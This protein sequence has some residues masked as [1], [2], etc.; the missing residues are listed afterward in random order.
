MASGDHTI[1]THVLDTETGQPARASRC[2]SAAS[3][4]MAR[5]SRSGE[6]TTDAD[7]RIASLLEEPSSPGVYRHHVRA[8][9]VPAAMLL[10]RGRARDQ[11]RRHDPLLPRA[12]AGGAVRRS[13]RTGA[14]D[15]ACRAGRRTIDTARAQFAALVAPLFEDAPRFIGRLAD[16]RPF[17][18]WASLFARAEAL[19]LAMP[20]DEQLELIDAHPRIGAPPGSVSALSFGEQGYD[21][22][23]PTPQPRPSGRACR[24][25]STSSTR[26]RGALRLPVRGLRGGAAAG[27]DRAADGGGPRRGSRRRASTEPCAT[28][29]RSA[30]AT[31]DRDRASPDLR[32]S[33]DEA[34]DPLRQGRGLDLPD[35][36]PGRSR[37]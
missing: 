8:A 24:R 29:S 22:E 16:A 23:R 25:R 37:A 27:G 5:S 15:A 31:G 19:A 20:D 30:R 33:T 6:G 12:A 4:P 28:S 13:A 18:S 26:V 3:W 34:G 17:G 11:R 1:S 2:A 9:R 35:R 32:R 21:R 7:G 10:P 14:A 36:G